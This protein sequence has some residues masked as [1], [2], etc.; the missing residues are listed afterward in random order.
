MLRQ[1]EISS[2]N[3]FAL[4][5]AQNAQMQELRDRYA[6]LTSRERQV[7]ALVERV[8]GEDATGLSIISPL[9]GDWSPCTEEG[10]GDWTAEGPFLRGP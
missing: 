1:T 7:M 4:S 10:G 2:P 6:S 9:M 3:D 5:R 8:R